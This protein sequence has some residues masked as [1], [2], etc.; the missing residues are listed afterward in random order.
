MRLKAAV[1]GLKPTATRLKA[2]A[3]WLKAT[4][5]WIVAGTDQSKRRYHDTE[6]LIFDRS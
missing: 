1:I 6:I 4:A 2:T 3:T 5:T